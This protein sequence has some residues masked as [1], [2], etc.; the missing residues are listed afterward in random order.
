M[1]VSDFDAGSASWG[2]DVGA[3]AV[4][5]A[6]PAPDPALAASAASAEVAAHGFPSPRAPNGRVL[7]TD[8]SKL[9]EQG[10]LKPGGKAALYA[11]GSGPADFHPERQPL[12]LVHGIDGDPKN[13]Q[14]VADRFKNDPRFQ[15]YVLCYDDDGR[16]TSLNGDDFAAEL[17]SLQ[18]KTLG[19]GRDVTIVAH[20]MGGI[21]TRRALD[22][23]AVG[24]GGGLDK[25]G[26]VRFV[27]VDTPWHGYPGPS[28]TGIGGV[29]MSVVRP[30][31]PDGLEDMRAQSAMFAGDPKST[32]PAAKAGLFGV[33]LPDNVDTELCFAQQGSD[34]QDYT[35]AELAP[36]AQDLAD[37]FNDDKPVA[38]EPRLMNFWHA[39][40]ASSQYDGFADEL[41]DDA[42]AGRITAATV[43]AA[44][45]K[46][47]PRFP[48][49]HDGVLNGKPFLDWLSQ[50]VATPP[51][52]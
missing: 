40:L 50:K 25:L 12:I 37:H 43:Q 8:L 47:F 22:D 33:E 16:R 46:W 9:D 20:S 32:D 10:L 39:I 35:E 45:L 41:R 29:M 23:L 1:S 13:L 24:P 2:D 27:A 18:Q 4:D 21:V 19:A 36:L 26:N 34:I 15:V 14:A 30:F 11:L 51:A 3:D 6:P 7:P 44:L 48:G 42:D 31:M 17:R 5:L 38:G 52:S 28:D 49:D